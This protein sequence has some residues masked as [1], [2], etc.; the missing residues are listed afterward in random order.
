MKKVPPM[1]KPADMPSPAEAAIFGAL[2]ANPT[3]WFT[4][5][6]LGK[7][8]PTLA[9]RTITCHLARLAGLGLADRLWTFPWYRYRLSA[10]MDIEAEAYAKR[11][12]T[13]RQA[14]ELHLPPEKV[15]D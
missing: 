13:I 7:Q 8:V 9:V 11:L 3:I 1:P 4:S 5:Q 2:A 12:E 14:L 15:D 6:T 10:S